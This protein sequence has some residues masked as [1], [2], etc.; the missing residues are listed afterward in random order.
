[1]Q[2]LTWCTK[3]EHFPPLITVITKDEE[4]EHFALQTL[5]IHSQSR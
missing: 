3:Y 1:M 5:N 2:I 4:R